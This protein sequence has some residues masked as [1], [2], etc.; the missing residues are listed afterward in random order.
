[1]KTILIAMLLLASTAFA[2]RIVPN[3]K[4][5]QTEFNRSGAAAALADRNNASLAFSKESFEDENDSDSDYADSDITAAAYISNETL[6]LEATHSRSIKESDND[7]Y[8]EFKFT[9]INAGKK[10]NKLAIGA[11]ALYIDND[12][13]SQRSLG[14]SGSYDVGNL[15]IGGG[16][17]NS[18]ENGLDVAFTEFYAG[19]GIL[20]E[21]MA[22]EAV[23]THQASE[24]KDGISSNDETGLQLE[25]TIVLN[26][27]QL[28]PTLSY[29]T[30]KNDEYDEKTKNLGLSFNLEYDIN[31]SLFIGG[32]VAR[33]TSSTEDTED[34]DND[35]D[36]IENSLGLSFRY[37]QDAFQVIV[38]TNTSSET[39]EFN[40]GADDNDYKYTDINLAGTYFF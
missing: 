30:G 24:K 13:G 2:G 26:K 6:N 21:N 36:T 8:R 32:T 15:L 28:S 3:I 35:I 34:S 20:K 38:S 31:G 29:A 17:Q 19:V 9:Y 4:W 18:H 12:D 39:V 25:G 22:F 37:K 40:D 23:L 5:N 10:L 1:M 33:N 7:N 16:F 11:T 14:L 27:F